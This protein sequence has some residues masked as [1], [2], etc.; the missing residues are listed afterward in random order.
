MEFAIDRMLGHGDDGDGLPVY[1]VRW[2]G[3]SS[4]DDT[5]KPV[6]NIPENFLRRY[7]VLQ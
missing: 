2:C 3:H 7:H 1:S 6:T 5:W 4:K